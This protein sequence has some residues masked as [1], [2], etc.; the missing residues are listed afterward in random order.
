MT[1][2]HG[3]FLWYELM[4]RDAARASA[5]YGSVVGWQ[6]ADAPPGG[7]EYRMIAAPDGNAGGMLQLDNAMLAAGAKPTWLVYF[8][9]DDVDASVAA[10]TAAGGTVLVPAWDAAG[11]GRIAMVTDPQGIPFY[12]MRGATEDATSTVFQRNGLGHVGWNELLTPDAEAALGFYH[13]QFGLTRLGGMPMG[14]MG[15]YSFI[16]READAPVGA[17]MR[18]PPGAAPGWSFYFRVD[19]VDAAKDRVT[20]GGGT[21]VMEPMDV[22][23]GERVLQAADPDGALFGL[24]SGQESG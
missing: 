6:V 24:V 16:G 7:P 17:I 19:D 23:G 12:V 13:R 1:N 10:I 8:A 5:F 21:I 15:E 4:T 3:D 14:E 11:V 22:P 9:A 2:R 20:A 18:S